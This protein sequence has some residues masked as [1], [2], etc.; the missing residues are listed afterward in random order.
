[1]PLNS[2][3]YEYTYNYLLLDKAGIWHLYTLSVEMGY[4]YISEYVSKGCI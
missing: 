3:V 2:C 1:M 4:R